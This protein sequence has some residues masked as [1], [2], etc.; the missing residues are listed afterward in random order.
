MTASPAP[1][2]QSSVEISQVNG[3][4][5]F[6]FALLSTATLFDGFDAAM[7]T[8]AAPDTRKTLEISLSEWGV[9]FGITRLGMVAS[10]FFLFFAD[11]WGRRTL[12][13]LTIVGFAI[14]N[15]LTAFA[16]GKLDF[17]LYQFLAR[18]FLTAEYSLAIIMIGEEFP[19]RLRG[20]AIAILTSFATIGVMTVALLHSYILLGECATG[21]VAEGTCVP[22][23]G[24]WLHDGGQVVV[25]WIQ[26]SLGQTVDRADWRVL[27]LIG[28]L[29]LALVFVLRL[30]MRETRRFAA[31][32][33]AKTPQRRA[34]REVLRVQYAHAKTPWQPEYRRRT[35]L[36]T[37]LWNCVHLVTAPA[38]AFWVIYAREEL[39]FTPSVVGLI[40]FWGYAGGIVGHFV[41]GYL[42]DRI[43]RKATCSGFY[44]F[45]AIAIFML[46]QVRTEA[47]QYLW[48][49]LTVFGFASA[50]TA[51][52]VYASELFPTAIRATG[53]G[54]TT[55]LFGRLTEVGTP[56]V[57]AAFISTLG[58]SGAV[59][60]T[61]I[62]PILGALLVMRYAP[63][64]KGLTLEEVQQVAAGVTA[65]PAT[66]TPVC[67]SASEVS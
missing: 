30:G 36:V 51:T 29:P 62:G 59:A 11:R 17:T 6:L 38:V 3:Y 13:M 12:M 52:H 40:I 43:G 7:L 50:N 23:Q 2:S 35:L 31:E 54:W 27:Y 55:N 24:N 21:S 56:F 66:R 44:I 33:R 16:T 10:F 63:E 5:I 15:S 65:V 47:G 42:I 18:V 20:R 4:L 64:T 8:V 53:Y 26:Q 60:V 37:L 48:M 45:A 1:A 25:A 57:I 39:S 67:K 32:Q 58:I 22:P 49:I 9:I 19:A 41:A 14:F 46:F 61:A 34:F 28:V